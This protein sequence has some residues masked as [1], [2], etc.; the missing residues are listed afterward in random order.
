VRYPNCLLS[1]SNKKK[2][3]KE[4]LKGPREERIL[5]LRG[6]EA[7][8]DVSFRQKFFHLLVELGEREKKVKKGFRW[9]KGH[10]FPKALLLECKGKT[11]LPWSGE[12]ES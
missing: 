8:V 7:L 10:L 11:K 9:K 1:S 6:K 3:G 12:A 4:S 2:V 5:N